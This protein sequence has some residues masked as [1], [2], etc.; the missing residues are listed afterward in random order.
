[1]ACSDEE[2]EI[3]R[4]EFAYLTREHRLARRRTSIL[5]VLFTIGVLVEISS[6]VRD[7]MAMSKGGE[8]G[9]VT[10]KG[11]N[12]DGFLRVR[13]IT[14]VDERGTE[15]VVIGAP[16][17]DPILLGRRSKRGDPVS[18]ILIFDAEGNERGGYGTGDR[19]RGAFLT[20]D[21][22]GRAA[23]ILDVDDRGPIEFSFF[24]TDRNGVRIGSTPRGAY[25]SMTSGGKTSVLFPDSLFAR[26]GSR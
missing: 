6:H 11:G 16:L 2:Y 23:L 25:L 4:S 10:T 15:R 20:L 13:G 1:M 7:A 17:P 9:S 22:V 14:V 24:D 3:L 12:R 19:S 18:G 8:I 26:G 5:A 21:Q